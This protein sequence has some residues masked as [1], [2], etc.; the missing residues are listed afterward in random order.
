MSFKLS[1]LIFC[2]GI[3]P[4]GAYN[5]FVR[6]LEKR[7]ETDAPEL[8]A[9][10]AMVHM[11]EAGAWNRLPISGLSTETMVDANGATSKLSQS[12]P[13]PGTI[14]AAILTNAAALDGGKQ[15][16]RETRWRLRGELRMKYLDAWRMDQQAALDFEQAATMKLLEEESSPSLGG[17]MGAG[18][19]GSWYILRS[20]RLKMEDMKRMFEDERD[21]TLVEL[22]ALFEKPIDPSAIRKS[23][24]NVR[25]AN[26]IVKKEELNKS[27]LSNAP[28]IKGLEAILRQ[29]KAMPLDTASR[30]FPEFFAQ[31]TVGLN[32]S[33]SKT[34]LTT[35]EFGLKWEL[36]WPVF[37]P[38]G[39]FAGWDA[40]IRQ[41]REDRTALLLREA[42]AIQAEAI[43][44]ESAKTGWKL[45][46]DRLMPATF[47]AVQETR[48]RFLAG[49]GSLTEALMSTEKL[50][51]AHERMIDY[52]FAM[53]KS[54]V[55]IE[56][57]LARLAEEMS[58]WMIRETGEH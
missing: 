39:D 41:A 49:T 52:R 33:T 25:F 43:R 55:L 27:W 37:R 24:E 1:L 51:E 14:L 21:A 17:R 16:V 20:E 53:E 57:H 9:K 35:P 7:L 6:A 3:V 22:S 48:S 12:V 54:L 11:L 26:Y 28:M 29:K 30:L 42:G 15:M 4:L 2:L 13:F 56:T 8:R 44:Y 5:D 34:S 45:W 36:P 32:G 19:S 47:Q 40:E 50:H 18:N 58:P 23:F 38:I 46:R 31:T 10:L